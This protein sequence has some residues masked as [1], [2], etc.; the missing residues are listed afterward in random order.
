MYQAVVMPHR[1]IP[2]RFEPVREFFLYWGFAE[3]PSLLVPGETIFVSTS[4][5]GEWLFAQVVREPVGLS[6]NVRLVIYGEDETEVNIQREWL[7]D[8]LKR[9]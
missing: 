9:K 8:E 1:D 5:L 6:F 4:C 3:V 7:M 2:N